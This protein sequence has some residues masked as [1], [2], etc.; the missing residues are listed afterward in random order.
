MKR[1][2]VRAALIVL[3]LAAL[4]TLAGCRGSAKSHGGTGTAAP[5]ATALPPRKLV[6]MAGFRPQAN[7]PF[8]AVYLAQAKGYFAQEGL[9][10]DIRHAT[11][12]EHLNLLLAKEVQFT[13]ATGPQVLRRRESDLPLRAIALFGQRGD[14]G[15][16]VRTDS[17]INTPA[18]LK[19][20]AIGFKSGVVPA[21]LK[22]LLK[23]AGLAESDVRLREVGNDPREFVAGTVDVYP[24]FLSNEPDTLRRIGAAI[25]VIDPADYGVPTLGLT[26]IAH[27]DTV[28]QDGDLV[29]R[30]LRATM[31]GALYARDHVDEGVQA[32]LTYAPGADPAHER[33]LL[34]T[35]LRAAARADGVG[36]ADLAQW[37]RLEATLREFGVTK[38]S[39]DVTT[40]WDGS[41]IDALYREG[42]L[43]P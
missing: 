20:R 37:Q 33:F 30:F 43:R 3:A 35:D 19:G 22:G 10:V 8:V 15:Y 41:F 5:S 4:V 39:V 7:L 2:T 26:Y 25:R 16:V 42:T 11:Q 14:Q 32:T 40:A 34:E 21:E 27:A 28:Q 12:G 13:T 1:M 6:F 18:D 31:R 38:K 36:R 23:S 24:V 17:G 29:Q 9:E